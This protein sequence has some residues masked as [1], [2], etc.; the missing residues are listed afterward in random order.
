M[1]TVTITRPD[2][3]HYTLEATPSGEFR[4][5]IQHDERTAINYISAI[6]AI[7]FAHSMA[8][9]GS[10]LVTNYTEATI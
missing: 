7:R 2:A 6:G 5:T 4:V 10:K 9:A 8:R 3:T 1:E